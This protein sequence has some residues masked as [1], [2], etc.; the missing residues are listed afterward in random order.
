MCR[1]I[2][3][4]PARRSA[5]TAASWPSCLG[6]NL[7]PERH[8][9]RAPRVL[10]GLKRGRRL[11]RTSAGPPRRRP[12]TSPSLSADGRTVAFATAASN[13]VPGDTNNAVDILVFDRIAG[14][15]E[16]VSVAPGGV[17]QPRQP[18][19]LDLR[20]GRFV[21]SG[22]DAT[23]LVPGDTTSG[24]TLRPRPPCRHDHRAEPR[25]RADRPGVADGPARP[26]R[27]A[28]A[29]DRTS[30]T[31]GGN[32]LPVG[33]LQPR[34]RRHQLRPRH[35][36][37]RPDARPGL[38]A[39]GAPTAGS[40]A[41]GTRAS[42]ARRGP[43]LKPIVGMA[44]TPSGHGYWLVASDGGIFAFGDAGFLG[45]TGAHQA[46]P[47]DRRDGGHPVGRRLLAGRARRR[48]LRLRRRRFLRFDRCDAAEPADRRH[49]R[50]ADG[51]GL[52]AGRPRRWDLRLRRR[53]ASSA[54]P[55]R[56]S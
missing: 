26:G 9:R 14:V 11:V 22:S 20:D 51:P 6:R 19:P 35:L 33:R 15:L 2:S 50:H 7:V 49:G 32:R 41:Y 54:R 52:L 39:G 12:S 42:T 17:G 40:S 23:D 28:E 43:A 21:A 13:L 8:R 29:P 18:H 45:S 27:P 30:A 34:R 4:S 5:A 44:A 46:G 25:A 16:R 36:R 48:D 47:A 56:S 3:S 1:R 37:P 38:L 55:A 31:A 10:R 53:R 24:P